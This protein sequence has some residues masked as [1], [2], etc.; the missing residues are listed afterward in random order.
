MTHNATVAVAAALLSVTTLYLSA[1]AWRS[2]R[3][4]SPRLL[5]G[6][7]LAAAGTISVFW[8]AVFFPALMSP[9]SL[10]QWGQAVTGRLTSW[11]PI[12]MT[13]VM[14]AVH[15][16]FASLSSQTQVA[17]TAWI[18]GTLFWFSIF[19]L[20]GL[21]KLNVRTKLLLCAVAALY[22]PIW[23]YTVTLWK[24]VWM[25]ISFFPLIWCSQKLFLA[26]RLRWQSVLPIL[27]LLELTMLQRQTAWISFS[28]LSF[29]MAPVV[30]SKFGAR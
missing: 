6:L 19:L 4:A 14:R 1:R 29:A 2:T 10:N 24:D 30:F 27:V 15:V 16:S 13:L 7:A 17:I 21:A 12:G 3:I 23:L 28:A 22:Y 18:Q 5:V 26:A 11:H 25:A 8:V 20:I 9:D